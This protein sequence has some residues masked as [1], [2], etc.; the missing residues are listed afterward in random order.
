MSATQLLLDVQR[1]TADLEH[2]RFIVRNALKVLER[3]QISDG[4]YTYEG[5]GPIS[6]HFSVGFAKSTLVELLAYLE[7][8]P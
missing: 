2:A 5:D 7:S 1:Q 4:P 6:A 3:P 8:L